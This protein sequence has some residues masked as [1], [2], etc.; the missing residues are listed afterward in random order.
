LGKK[1][2]I[3][4][5]PKLLAA[6]QQGTMVTVKEVP[7]VPFIVTHLGLVTMEELQPHPEQKPH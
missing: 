4:L 7:G 6:L 1:M 5:L 2:K 3:D